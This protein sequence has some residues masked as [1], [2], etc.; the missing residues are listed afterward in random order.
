MPPDLDY[1]QP[2]ICDDELQGQSALPSITDGGVQ[3]VD[4]INLKQQIQ[5]EAQRHSRQL[6]TKLVAKQQEN[7]TRMQDKYEAYNSQVACP[8]IN[9]LP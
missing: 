4:I 8:S 1:V 9:K 5:T 3:P 6:D 7:L 2:D